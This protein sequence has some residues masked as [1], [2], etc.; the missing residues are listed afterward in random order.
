MRTEKKTSNLREHRTREDG[1]A[2]RGDWGTVGE[3]GCCSGTGGNTENRLGY[4]E[5]ILRIGADVYR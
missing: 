5:Q 3:R 1:K 4:S 2:R